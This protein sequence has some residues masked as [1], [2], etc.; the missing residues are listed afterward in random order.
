MAR[1]VHFPCV[2]FHN[3]CSG[4]WLLLNGSSSYDTH[5]LI[6]ASPMSTVTL[7]WPYCSTSHFCS[8]LQRRL[9][10][11]VAFRISV[12]VQLPSVFLASRIR[13]K[14]ARIFPSRWR[15]TYSGFFALRVGLA[16]RR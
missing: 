3:A 6:H 4:H 9:L 10:I 2:R 1:G 8:V 7:G 12:P 13:C 14:S 16:F 11:P 5:V 15:L